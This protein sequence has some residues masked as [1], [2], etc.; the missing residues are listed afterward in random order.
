MVGIRKGV[1][2]FLYERNKGTL[3][4]NQCIAVRGTMILYLCI[5][6]RNTFGVIENTFGLFDITLGVIEK[7]LGVIE[8]HLILFM[9]VLGFILVSQI[10]IM[11]TTSFDSS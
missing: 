6:D 10:S 2:P 8:T 3:S 7:S 9:R 1:M 11:I 5:K 4:E